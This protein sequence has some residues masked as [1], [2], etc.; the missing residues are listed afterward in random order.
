MDFIFKDKQKRMK[1]TGCK[2]DPKKFSLFKRDPVFSG[3][4]DFRTK[5]TMC[6][7]GLTGYV[8]FLDSFEFWVYITS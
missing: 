8:R 4:L 2:E 6:E 3:L 5:L 1:S 7:T